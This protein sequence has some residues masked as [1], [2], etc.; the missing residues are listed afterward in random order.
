MIPI[1]TPSEILK[2]QRHVPEH[3]RQSAVLIR[4]R[5]E[6]P[7]WSTS[8]EFLRIHLQQIHLQD[9]EQQSYMAEVF[10]PH[11]V[12]PK[13]C[14]KCNQFMHQVSESWSKCRNA[15][16][17]IFDKRVMHG[18]LVGVVNVLIFDDFVVGKDERGRELI[19]ACLLVLDRRYNETT[20]AAVYRTAEALAESLGK[21]LA[22]P[23]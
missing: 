13:R 16:C 15:S 7:R 12:G 18:P 1:R 4:F 19:N 8:P 11:R 10:Q 21:P 6:H 22:N 3:L 5:E 20:L 23:A 17:Q 9:G 14:P 2:G